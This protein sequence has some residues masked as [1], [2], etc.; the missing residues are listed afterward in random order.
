MA[1]YEQALQWVLSHEGGYVNDPDDPGG[2]TYKGVARKMNSKWN[3]WT[4]IDM[5]K[6]QKGFPANLDKDSEL[7]DAVQSFYQVNYWDKIKGDEI[8]NQ[9]VATSIFDFAVNAGVSTSSS[10]AQLVVSA[11]KDGVI[12]NQSVQMIN[13]FDPDHFIASFTVAKIARYLNIVKN[14]PTSKKYF[15]GWV[16]RALGEN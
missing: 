14:R 1:N 6:R 16:C 5:L 12:G 13:G 9:E 11:E 3:G 2:E 7:Q 10:L 15:Y 4:I 8:A